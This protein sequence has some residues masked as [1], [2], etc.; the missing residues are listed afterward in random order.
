MRHWPPRLVTAAVLAGAMLM[1]SVGSG[2]AKG[3]SSAPPAERISLP[4]W[5]PLAK[6]IL[7]AVVN[8]TAEIAADTD[9]AGI[10]PQ[11]DGPAGRTRPE[12][13]TFDDFLRRYLEQHGLAPEIP[14]FP[15]TKAGPDRKTI[16]VGSAFIIDPSGY[17]VTNNHVVARAKKITVML[18]DGSQ[19]RAKLV[20]SD[21]DTDIALL[22]ISVNGSLPFV[23][24]GDSH[25]VEVGDWVLAVGNPF[26]LG[27]TVTAGIVSALGRDLQLTAIIHRM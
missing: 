25:S 22:K 6:R 15:Q 21:A 14:Q 1:A 18:S 9:A 24:W 13:S 11:R 2:M 8:V 16:S 3:N 5:A 20:G 26:G 4:S 10:D 19:H 12:T 27:G 7:P 23:E 17:I